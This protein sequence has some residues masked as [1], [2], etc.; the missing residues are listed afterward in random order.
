MKRIFLISLLL[1]GMALAEPVKLIVSPSASNTAGFHS[2]ATIES[3]D[4][5]TQ[6]LKGEITVDPENPSSAGPAWLE[7]DLR[8]LSTGLAMRDRHMRENHLHT[9]EF[10]LTRFDLDGIVAGELSDGT[11]TVI[12][13]DGR[14]QLHGVEKTR[15]IE[16]SVTWH[17][18]SAQ[19]DGRQAL[20]LQC[21]FPIALAEHKIPR[22]EFLFMK[23]AE[24]MEVTLDFWAVAP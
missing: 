21:S 13:L 2:D 14:V 5:S 23:V 20:H 12:K 19:H 22:P 10:P 18:A 15:S 7:V 1:A 4:G 9:D 6:A 8:E 17:D 3:F 24:E 16:A 11:T